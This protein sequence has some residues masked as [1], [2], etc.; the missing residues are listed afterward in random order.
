[1]YAYIW[2]ISTSQATQTNICSWSKSILCCNKV[3]KLA[4][5]V[6][7]DIFGL[8]NP[9]LGRKQGMIICITNVISDALERSPLELPFCY[10][11]QFL[12][13]K[14]K[15]STHPSCY[16]ANSSATHQLL[17]CGGDI[18]TNTGPC[19]NTTKV[20]KTKCPICEKTVRKNKY[21]A[22]CQICY[23]QFHVKCT[24]LDLTRLK[25]QQI[26]NQL[27]VKNWTCSRCL[28]SMLPF[29][30]V[31]SIDEPLEGINQNDSIFN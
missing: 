30:S 16:Y 23:D 1:M 11:K 3:Y 12:H 31:R 29:H 14:I 22:V 13:R 27:I 24:E 10:S 20:P 26:Q 7:L 28:L 18:A 6:N 4:N 17:L 19:T 8:E 2:Q 25:R 15:R 21:S 9:N 5:C